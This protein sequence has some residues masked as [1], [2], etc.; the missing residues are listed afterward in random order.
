MTNEEI[1]Q[2]ADELSKQYNCNVHPLVFKAEDETEEIIGYL[3]EPQ[4]QVKT[5]LMDR[6]IT[7]QSATA[8]AEI[9]EAYIIKEHSDNRIYHR[10]SE[11]DRYFFG[12][13]KEM[14]NMIQ[15]SINHFKKK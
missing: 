5:S 4:R 15:V 2:K 11:N 9:L 13:L 1:Q 14:Y 3:K 7:Q 6:A 12:A 10:T 8:C